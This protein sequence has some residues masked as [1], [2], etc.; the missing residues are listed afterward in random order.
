MEPQCP[1]PPADRPAA[2][3]RAPVPLVLVTGFLGAGKTT[4]LRSLLQHLAGR[5]MAADVILN[6][7]GNASL[8]AVSLAEHAASLL[9]LAGSCACCETMDVMLDALVAGK[10][11]TSDV[12]LVELNGTADPIPILESL[13][14]LPEFTRCEPILQVAL[15]D[16]TRWGT[17]E[18]ATALEIQQVETASHLLITRLDQLPP[19]EAHRIR[20]EVAFHNP[21]ANPVTA[22]TFVALLAMLTE[23]RKYGF[24]TAA[25]A[26]LRPSS[27]D[28]EAVRRQTHA[29]TSLQ[30]PLPRMVKHSAILWWMKKLPGGVLRAKAL[31]AL[32]DAPGLHFLYQRVG[33]EADEFPIELP[34]G[35]SDPARRPSAVLIGPNLDPDAIA[36]LTREAFGILVEPPPAPASR[37]SI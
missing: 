10:D 15:V 22:V 26:P 32:A 34:P 37:F 30:V 31:V 20:D 35:A 9:P 24:P 6:D 17:R 25:A 16:A 2:I 18:F 1:A 14:L 33:S 13:S 5:G 4:F 11:R 36:T 28:P 3:P 19:A 7:Y 12:V 27:Q 8:D 23:Q 29:F 21:T